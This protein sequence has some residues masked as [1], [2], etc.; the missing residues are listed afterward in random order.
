MGAKFGLMFLT[1]MYI[2]PYWIN[3]VWLDVVTYLHHT[4]KEVSEGWP[5]QAGIALTAHG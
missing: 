1:K 3:V 2:I 4:D 5:M